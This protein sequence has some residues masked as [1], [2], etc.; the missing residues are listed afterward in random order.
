MI[1]NYLL[2]G[3]AAM[4][5]FQSFAQDVPEMVDIEGGSFWMGNDY[6]F[7]NAGIS[8]ESPEHKVTLSSFKLSKTEIPFD[9]FDLFCEATGWEKP[10]DG[11]NGRGKNPVNNVSWEA[12]VMFCNW[13][14]R[15]ERIDPY[16]NIQ[17]DSVSFKVTINETANGYR[18]PTEAEWEY[19]AR[20]GANGKTYTFSGS[21]DYKQVAW[22][23]MNSS[24]TPHEIGS[25][26]PNELGIHDM[27]GN[28]WEWCWDLYDKN[29]YKV[30]P[31][32]NPMGAEKGTDRVYR[33]GNW[34]STLEDLRMTARQHNA[35][36]Q[37]SGGVGIRL[38][39][40]K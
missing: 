11:K 5:A 14:S 26:E 19:A 36:N 24:L 10:S 13:L 15:R 29:Y 8:D 25:K 31:E 3:L 6:T 1:K 39:Q 17:R 23:K 33:G 7:K 34:T 40:N 28:V 22:C 38:A 18:L 37:A 35:P 9:L 20:G 21:N 27:S 4:F 2:T 32:N 16:Y 12:A 30:S